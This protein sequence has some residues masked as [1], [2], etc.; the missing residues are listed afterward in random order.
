MPPYDLILATPMT[1]WRHFSSH[2]GDVGAFPPTFESSTVRFPAGRYSPPIQ[3]R[4]FVSSDVDGYRSF[5]RR[6]VASEH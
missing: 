6:R 2:A 4:L 5:V 1:D 3:K